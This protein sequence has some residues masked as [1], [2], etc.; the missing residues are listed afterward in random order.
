MLSKRYK[1]TEVDCGTWLHVPSGTPWS[2]SSDTHQVVEKK[3]NV[4][5]FDYT[6]VAGSGKVGPVNQVNH[7][8]E[9]WVA[10]V[11]LTDRPKSVRKPLCNQTFF[12]ALSLL[13]L[14][15]FDI[16]VGEGAFVIGLSQISSFFSWYT[17][18]I[19]TIYVCV[20]HFNDLSAL[21]GCWS[22]VSIRRI[23]Y[24]F[25]NACPFDYTAIAVSGKVE[26]SETG[27]TTPVG[28]LLLFQLT[29]LSRSAIVV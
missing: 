15:P 7:T 27:L 18:I 21:V 10:V 16:S 22:S 12:V 5:P 29:I 1:S 20:P 26:R 13:I 14:C 23:I 11:T 19:I 25:L 9:S 3:L 2:T 8:S 28:W 4:C 24:K 6:V 17:I